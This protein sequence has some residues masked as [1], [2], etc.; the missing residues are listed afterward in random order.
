MPFLGRH[1][2]DTWDIFVPVERT[3]C[4]VRVEGPRDHY[5]KTTNILLVAVFDRRRLF[6]VR[7]IKTVDFPDSKNVRFDDGNSVVIYKSEHDGF[8]YR[9]LEDRLE[10]MK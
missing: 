10:E 1:D 4:W 3:N 6:Y 7:S 8:I 2:V 5:S 9:A